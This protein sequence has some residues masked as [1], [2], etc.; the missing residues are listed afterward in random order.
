MNGDDELENAIKENAQ[1][2]AKASGDSGSIEQHPLKDQIEADRYLA[3]KSAAKT[4][5][6]GLKFTKLVP[7]GAE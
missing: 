6:L 2:P 7:P 1:G 5:K 3:S 4:K